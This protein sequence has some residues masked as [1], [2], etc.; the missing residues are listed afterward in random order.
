LYIGGHFLEGFQSKLILNLILPGLGWELLAGCHCSEVA[1]NT[2]LTVVS[3]KT[4][5]RQIKTPHPPSPVYQ[6]QLFSLCGTLLKIKNVSNTF[7]DREKGFQNPFN[8][9][10]LVNIS[11]YYNIQLKHMLG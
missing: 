1:V 11:K 3:I 10:C 9:K 2:G 5:S 4:M 6:L 7:Y 8:K